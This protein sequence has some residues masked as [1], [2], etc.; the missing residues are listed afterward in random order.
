MSRSSSIFRETAPVAAV[1][2]DICWGPDTVGR[3]SLRDL[4]LMLHEGEVLALLG[5]A[6]AGR[7]ALIR[8]LDGQLRGWRGTAI[9]LAQPLRPDRPPPRRRRRRVALL[10]ADP[11]LV[12]AASVARN[13]LMGRLGH[14]SGLASLLGR[15]S[16]RDRRIVSAAME[17]TG[18]TM[19][20]ARKAGQLEAEERRQV[21]LARCLAQEPRLLLAE[22]LPGTLGDPGRE[23]THVRRLARIARGRRIP[24]VIGC[25]HADIALRHA[26]RVA[27][28]RH[29]SVALCGATEA[30]SAE[31]R[32]R[33]LRG[34]RRGGGSDG[35][36][37]VV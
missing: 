1:L 12:E 10:E 36:R 6:G 13:V 32:A 2:R 35:L 31:D 19:L 17:E 8:L 20:A 7:N 15:F 3:A 29:G 26:D 11:A 30:L 33:L 23:D 16:E 34:T 9:V 5:R 27:L 28:L 4:R 24:L 25:S 18:L 21:A 22:T 14:G 37:L